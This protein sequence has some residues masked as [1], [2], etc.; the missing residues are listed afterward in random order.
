[1]PI[2]R[3]SG[4][5]W[6]SPRYANDLFNSTT[7]FHFRGPSF[8]ANYLMRSAK[9]KFNGFLFFSSFVIGICYGPSKEN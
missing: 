2:G 3:L 9:Q 8:K 4:L 5:E 7:A 6:D 1:M